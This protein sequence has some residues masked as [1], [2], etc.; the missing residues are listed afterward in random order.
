MLSS[1]SRFG[2]NGEWSK[3]WISGWIWRWFLKMLVV[4]HFVFISDWK[5]Q[6]K[7]KN[8][9]W[10]SRACVPL[11]SLAIWSHCDKK[12]P[13]FSKVQRIK[14]SCSHR[15]I[16]FKVFSISDSYLH[17]SF[18]LEHLKN[19]VFF[20]TAQAHSGTGLWYQFRDDYL[21]FSFFSF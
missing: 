21:Y 18:R 11:R 12:T 7:F 16:F 13:G 20:A 9:L 6:K 5:M 1:A 19:H 8:R 14:S 17:V 10:K 15:I 4:L 2:E 3:F